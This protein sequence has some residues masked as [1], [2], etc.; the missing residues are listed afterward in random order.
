MTAFPPRARL[1]AV[2]AA[3]ARDLPQSHAALFEAQELDAGRT[4]LAAMADAGLRT[5]TADALNPIEADWMADRLLAAWARIGSPRV[6]PAACLLAP[7]D[8]WLPAG[9]A[10]IRLE[11]VVLG[12]A[13]GWEVRWPE[14]VTGDGAAATLIAAAPTGEGAATVTVSAQVIGRL[15]TRDGAP[16]PRDIL[17]AHADIA[18]RR[19]VAARHPDGRRL[20]IRDQTG[21]PAAGLR[22]YLDGRDITVPDDGIVMLDR[23][24]PPG[25]TAMIADVAVPVGEAQDGPH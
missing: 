7:D 8:M 9:E 17:H 3:L 23:A 16:G 15:A 20:T 21:R 5:R 18:L 22:L 6:G 10:E 11:V 25:T 4:A 13:P 2:L 19:P 14:T 24:L 1:D 12:M